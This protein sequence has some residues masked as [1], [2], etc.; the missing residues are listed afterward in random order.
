[1]SKFMQEQLRII[2][3]HIRQSEGRV[4]VLWEFQS[5]EEA[6]QSEEAGEVFIAALNESLSY[7]RKGDFEQALIAF[8]AA[9][10]DYAEYNRKRE[11]RL[12]QRIAMASEDKDIAAVIGYMGSVHTRLAH[13]LI[14][15]GYKVTREFPEMENGLYIW[16][17]M[18]Q[19]LRYILF[20]PNKEPSEIEWYRFMIGA[21]IQAVYLSFQ[22]LNKETNKV[23]SDQHITQA[24][25]EK[26]AK[27][28]DMGSIAQLE[29]D[30]RGMGFIK[31]I[32]VSEEP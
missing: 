25:I 10:V 23:M 9:I 1:M 13:I 15:E 21:A 18:D 4:R 24:T 12:A 31:A 2:D 16:G 22:K 19:A 30:I 26:L 8:K 20:F 27:F 5:S 32:F 29:K 6:L 11:N 7:V 3:R 14:R 28:K 17:L